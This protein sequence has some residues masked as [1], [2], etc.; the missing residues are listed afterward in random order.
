MKNR[1]FRLMKNLRII[2]AVLAILCSGLV[3][4]QEDVVYS[5]LKEVKN[6]NDVY[7]LKLNYQRLRKIPPQVFTFTNL[8]VLDLSKNFIDSLPPE[9]AQLTNLKEL[10]LNRNKIRF[11][12]EHIGQ[13]TNLE[14]LNLSRNPILELPESLGQ[15]TNLKELI[16]F[17]TGIIS[18]PPTCFTLNYSLQVLDLRACPLTYDNQQAIEEILPSPRKRWD[19][20]CNCK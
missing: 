18:V 9:L 13:L 16:L 15:L 10:N 19:Y 11:V 6:P 7:Q 2:L 12:P 4:A 17:M 1:I 3:W 20:V 5:S 8:R 14:I